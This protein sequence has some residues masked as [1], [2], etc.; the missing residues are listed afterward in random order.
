MAEATS[1]PRGSALRR[2]LDR[3]LG[4]LAGALVLSLVALTC[5]DVVGRYL[6][7]APLAGAF[8]LTQLGV[9]ALVFCALPLTTE[10]GGHVEVDLVFGMTGPAMRRAMTWIGGVLSAVCL[11]AIAWRIGALGLRQVEDGSVTDA[12]RIPYAP[13]AFAMAALA[14]LSAVLSLFRAAVPANHPASAATAAAETP[15]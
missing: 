12:L 2:T 4:A 11:A 14:A 13:L 10:R 3:S 7:N 15:R 9:A 5:V 8:E 6:L 1:P